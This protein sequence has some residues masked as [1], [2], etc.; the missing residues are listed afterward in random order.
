M[1]LH[2]KGEVT[3]IQPQTLFLGV[4]GP[5]YYLVHCG[6]VQEIKVDL[7]HLLG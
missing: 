6:L 5:L 3:P 7:V 1:E 4:F 2:L